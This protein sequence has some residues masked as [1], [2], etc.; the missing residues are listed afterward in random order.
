LVISWIAKKTSGKRGPGEGTDFTSSTK[1]RNC[2]F[3]AHARVSREES[4]SSGLLP[5]LTS[6]QNGGRAPDLAQEDGSCRGWCPVAL[7]LL[8]QKKKQ[9]TATKDDRSAK[10]VDLHKSRK[11]LNGPRN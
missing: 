1:R 10:T 5:S 7:L 2:H 8:R 6:R 11:H 4:V 3:V 9:L